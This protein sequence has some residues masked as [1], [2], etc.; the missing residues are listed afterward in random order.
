MKIL[1]ACEL[2][3]HAVDELRGLGTQLVYLPQASSADLLEAITDTAVAV[4][5]QTPVTPDVFE[6][7][8]A[9]QM[10]VYAGSGSGQIA[11][12]VASRDGIFVTHC[13]G[14]DAVA[15]AELA[16]GLVLALDRNIV[17][18]ADR[19]REGTWQRADYLGGRGLQGGT[20]GIIGD[21]PFCQE[22]AP[23]AAALGMD[24][25]GWLPEAESEDLRREGI[26]LCNW[27]RELARRSDFVVIHGTTAHGRSMGLGQHLVDRNFLESMKPGASLVH[28]GD[29]ANLNEEEVIQVMQ[30]RGLR[31]AVD[32]CPGGE[33]GRVRSNLLQQPGVVGT[34]H[35][36][37][38][39]EQARD[40]IADE[41]V[42]TVAAFLVS[43]DIRH[44]LNLA[45]RSP[46]TWLLVLRIRDQVG[47]MAAILQAIRADGINAEEITSRVFAG[48]QA[49]WCTIS[50][51]ERPSTDALD[52]IRALDDVLH[53]E[54]R[55]VV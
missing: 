12:D 38:A 9:L 50:L 5:R 19:L 26:E 4:V 31:V 37:G 18:N 28:I 52:A 6:R 49:A 15:C 16:L 20:L 36:G 44:P 43:G 54:L 8:Q 55:A 45:E 2:P 42:K 11:V 23:R 1:V 51:D 7:A 25:L 47:V 46:A 40:A 14:T 22:L 21:P 24:L 35:T 13:P 39:T 48:A 41:V 32:V 10:V 3:E 33:G 53:L 17:P 29:I 27:P 30:E 34:I